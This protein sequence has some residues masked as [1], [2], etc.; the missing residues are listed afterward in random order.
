MLVFVSLVSSSFDAS[1]FFSYLR[2][3]SIF[4]FIFVGEASR[5]LKFSSSSLYLR[6]LIYLKVK[7]C[8]NFHF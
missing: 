5:K 4:L 2:L 3:S 7:H 8:D 6:I 1:F